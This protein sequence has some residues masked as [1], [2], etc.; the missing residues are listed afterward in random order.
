MK[1]L[2]FLGELYGGDFDI[3]RD[4]QVKIICFIFTLYFGFLSLLFLTSDYSGQIQYHALHEGNFGIR[5]FLE[6]IVIVMFAWG[7][8]TCLMG[9]II[10]FL[11]F[12]FCKIINRHETD[13][14]KKEKESYFSFELSYTMAPIFSAIIIFVMLFGLIEI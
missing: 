13:K 9:S 3:F 1:L 11:S 2:R 7:L 10:C 8:L 12:V 14:S 6:E 5:F 4:N